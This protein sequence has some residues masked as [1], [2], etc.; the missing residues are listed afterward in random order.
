MQFEYETDENRTFLKRHRAILVS[1]GL[2]ILVVGVIYTARTL[3]QN[4]HQQLRH[5][6]E[7]TLNLPPSTPPPTPPPRN[8]PTPVP[9]PEEKQEQPMEAQQPVQEEKKTEAPKEKPLDAPAPLGTGITGPGGGQDLGLSAGLGG[10]GGG[11]GSGG[12]GTKYGWYASEIQT[13]IADAVRNDPRMRGTQLS[14]V[15]KI[16]PDATGKIIKAK[17]SSAGNPQ[18]ES[19]VRDSILVGLQLPDA[20]PA[21][22]PL[23]I[24]MRLNVSE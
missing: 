3:T 22:M 19:I 2:V 10:N 16:W 8:T 1:C 5:E 9:T 11:Y 23:P 13:H 20:P 6:E 7:F 14:V 24:V 18:L 15:V 12:G 17:V 4:N 21:D